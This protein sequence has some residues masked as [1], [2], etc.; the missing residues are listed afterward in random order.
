MIGIESHPLTD[1][2]AVADSVLKM[3]GVS[4]DFGAVEHCESLL[5][6]R[7]DLQISATRS[8]QYYLDITHLQAN[9][10]NAVLNLSEVLEI[11]CSEIAT[12]GDMPTDISMFRKSG[13]SIAMGNA[14]PEVQLAA[15]YVTRSHDEDGFAEAMEEYVLVFR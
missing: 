13:V 12:I 8:Q 11:P 5:Q 4:D 9:K 7:V 3:V 6:S 10:G 1:L 14:S 2:D 15:M